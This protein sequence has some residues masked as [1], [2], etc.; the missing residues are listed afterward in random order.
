MSSYF[1]TKKSIYSADCGKDPLPHS[2]MEPL[3]MAR[4]PD[5]ELERLKNEVGYVLRLELARFPAAKT[6]SGRLRAEG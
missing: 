6:E 2:E 1:Q 5:S 4:I 3:S